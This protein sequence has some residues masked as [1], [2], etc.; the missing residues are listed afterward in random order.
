MYSIFNDECN[1]TDDECEEQI[2]SQDSIRQVPTNNVSHQESDKNDDDDEFDMERGKS[3]MIKRLLSENERYKKQVFKQ[4]TELKKLRLQLL[5]SEAKP[6]RLLKIYIFVLIIAFFF[7][8]LF[9][10]EVYS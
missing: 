4:E 8:N 10:I 6:R 5:E 3:I 7:Q 1:P 2:L 9:K